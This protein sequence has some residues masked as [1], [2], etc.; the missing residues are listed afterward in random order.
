[1]ALTG[2]CKDINY[3][4]HETDTEAVSITYPDGTTKEIQQPVR[5]KNEVDYENVYLC[6]KQVVNQN[7]NEGSNYSKHIYYH[8]AAYENKET[9]DADQEDFLFW[10]TDAFSLDHTKTLY[11]QV[12]EVIKT[13]EGLTDLIDA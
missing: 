9:R 11:E 7:L 12:Y 4:D 13:T 3:T 8:Y 2:N 5:V 6:I 1:M 10:K